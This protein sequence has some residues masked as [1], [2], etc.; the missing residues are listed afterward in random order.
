MI[1]N[2]GEHFVYSLSAETSLS[3]G[4]NWSFHFAEEIHC[5]C[6]I[7]KSSDDNFGLKFWQL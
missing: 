5:L 4:K 7:W 2:G 1:E 6:Y 3:D